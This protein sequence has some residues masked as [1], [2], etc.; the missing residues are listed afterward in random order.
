MVSE[1]F[2][3]KG[4][5]SGGKQWKIYGDLGEM[6]VDILKMNELLYLEGVGTGSS[7]GRYPVCE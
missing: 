3:L 6:I 1:L 7:N 4:W 5:G 2:F